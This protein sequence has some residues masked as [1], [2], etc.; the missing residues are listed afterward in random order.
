M[1]LT[2]AW[3]NIW[4]NKKRSLIIVAATA[5]GLACG[6]FAGAT[7][8][9]MWDSMINTT[10]DRDLGHFQIHT[11]S[12]ED[13]KLLTDTIPGFQKIVDQLQSTKFVNGVSS[14]T[15]IEG[16]VSSATSSNGVRIL[17]INPESE[18]NTTSIYKQ[19]I[20]GNYFQEDWKNQIVIGEKL[21]ENLGARIKSKI[22]LSFQGLDGSIIYGAF[23]V[24]GIY[25]T[26]SS[27]FD[28][29]NVF[30]KEDDLLKLINSEVI[31]NEI[32]VRVSS[33]QQLDSVYIPVKKMY[34]ELSVKYWGDLAPELKL[35]YE[36]L[37]TQMYIFVGIILFALL[38][39]ITNTMLMSVMERIREFGMLMAIG[40]KRSRVFLMIMMETISLSLIGG[41]V[42]IAFGLIFIEYF[43]YVGINLSA[44]TEGLS[45]WSLGTQLYTSLPF[46]FYPPLVLMIL[47]TAVIGAF[48][49]ALKAIKLKPA[50]AI[51][52]Y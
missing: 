38:F 52:T 14:R 35:F 50:T 32:V 48:Y 51:R 11:K 45:Q 39:G 6:L 16:M 9:G 49:P 15:I 37:F 22:V 30:I 42:G 19:T 23:R 34:P 41:V 10:I 40:M 8:Y 28:K 13:E 44:F 2:L 27:T 5:I 18:K 1:L 36:M 4:R 26:E 31:S 17:G 46:S 21:A 33:V 43:G 25:K 7:M 47:A 29:A 12:Y 20:Q 24:A 3:R